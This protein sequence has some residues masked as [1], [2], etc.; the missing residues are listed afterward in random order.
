M[1]M[2]MRTA[3]WRYMSCLSL[4]P[5]NQS[6]NDAVKVLKGE[7]RETRFAIPRNPGKD[8]PL[9]ETSNLKF[10]LNKVAYMADEVSS[11]SKFRFSSRADLIFSLVFIP[12]PILI[13]LN[14][15]SLFIV[16][17][18]AWREILPVIDNL[19]SISTEC[20]DERMSDLW[21]RERRGA[22]CDPG[23]IWFCRGETP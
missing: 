4:Y 21:Y 18:T 16:S 3:W 13:R 22:A 20:C 14:M 5:L 11:L 9:V 1:T 15:L 12:S 6:T 10:G 8:G 23:I 2:L 19:K 17:T 7:I